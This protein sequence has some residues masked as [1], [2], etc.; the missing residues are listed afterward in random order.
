MTS[1]TGN[2]VRSLGAIPIISVL[3]NNPTLEQTTTNPAL[4]VPYI[5]YYTS[6]L[7]EYQAIR[8][9]TKKADGTYTTVTESRDILQ[10]QNSN[11]VYPKYLLYRPYRSMSAFPM[12]LAYKGSDVSAISARSRRTRSENRTPYQVLLHDIKESDIVLTYRQTKTALSSKSSSFDSFYN[13]TIGNV[14][15]ELIFNMCR[16]SV[17]G[18]TGDAVSQG[19]QYILATLMS[20]IYVPQLSGDPYKTLPLGNPPSGT[21]TTYRKVLDCLMFPD[22]NS[23]VN[24]KTGQY[25]YTLNAKKVPIPSKT[26]NDQG[27]S[28]ENDR[29]KIIPNTTVTVNAKDYTIKATQEIAFRTTA[30]GAAQIMGEYFYHLNYKSAAEMFIDMSARADHYFEYYDGGPNMNM[31]FLALQMQKFL[32]DSGKYRQMLGYYNSGSDGVKSLSLIT[33]EEIENGDQS[34][35]LNITTDLADSVLYQFAKKY[36]G[37]NVAKPT[38]YHS[39]YPVKLKN[40]LENLKEN[41]GKLKLEMAWGKYYLPCTYKV[42][43]NGKVTGDNSGTPTDVRVPDKEGKPGGP[44]NVFELSA[45]DWRAIPSDLKDGGLVGP[46]YLKCPKEFKDI[47]NMLMQM[48]TLAL[49]VKFLPEN[50]DNGRKTLYGKYGEYIEYIPWAIC[51]VESGMKNY[52][53]LKCPPITELLNTNTPMKDGDIRTTLT[54]GDKIKHLTTN[55]NLTKFNDKILETALTGIYPNDVTSDKL[56]EIEEDP[57]DDDKKTGLIGSRYIHILNTS[58]GIL[59]NIKSTVEHAT[60]TFVTTDARSRALLRLLDDTIK[61]LTDLVKPSKG[62]DI[63][64]PKIAKRYKMYLQVI[65]TVVSKV[66]SICIIPGIR[67]YSTGT[68]IMATMTFNANVTVILLTIVAE[69]FD[70]LSKPKPKSIPYLKDTLSF[71]KYLLY[72]TGIKKMLSGGEQISEALLAERYN[73]QVRSQYGT[74]IDRIY[75]MLKV[76]VDVVNTDDD[77]DRQYLTEVGAEILRAS[78]TNDAVWSIESERLHNSKATKGRSNGIYKD[79]VVPNVSDDI[80]V[81]DTLKN[82][83]LIDPDVP[84]VSESESEPPQDF[85]QAVN[86]FN[87]GLLS[88]YSLFNKTRTT[89]IM[90]YRNLVIKTEEDRANKTATT[91]TSY[92]VQFGSNN[93]PIY[94]DGHE[95][96]IVQ[97]FGGSKPSIV[98]SLVTNDVFML[99]DIMAACQELEITFRT[100]STLRNPNPLSPNFAVGGSDYQQNS[101]LYNVTRKNLTNRIKAIA[102]SDASSIIGE[103]GVDAPILITNNVANMCG[104]YACIFNTMRASTMEGFP[105]TWNIDL[106]FTGVDISQEYR[107]TPRKKKTELDP[108]IMITDLAR[109]NYLSNILQFYSGKNKSLET[110]AY[111]TNFQV[112]SNATIANFITFVA[113]TYLLKLGI[114]DTDLPKPLQQFT[115]KDPSM[116]DLSE[117]AIHAFLTYF[118]HPVMESLGGVLTHTGI[119]NITHQD[120]VNKINDR[121]KAIATDFRLCMHSNKYSY[122]PIIIQDP[123]KGK[124]TEIAQGMA[125]ISIVGVAAIAGGVLPIAVAYTASS[126]LQHRLR[127]MF[128]EAVKLAPMSLLQILSFTPEGYERN[129]KHRSDAIKKYAEDNKGDQEKTADVTETEAAKVVAIQWL[130]GPDDNAPI[131]SKNF[132]PIFQN[133]IKDRLVN[134]VVTTESRG[135]YGIINSKIFNPKINHKDL[136]KTEDDDYNLSVLDLSYHIIGEFSHLL[137]NYEGFDINEKGPD[138]KYRKKIRSWYNI[139]NAQNI[140]QSTDIALASIV[141]ALRE[142]RK[143]KLFDNVISTAMKAPKNSVEDLTE[144]IQKASTDSTDKDHA[145]ASSCKLLYPE[146]VSNGGQ[147]EIPQT[148]LTMSGK[149]THKLAE[150][151]RSLSGSYYMSKVF[152]DVI[153]LPIN[154]DTHRRTTLAGITSIKEILKRFKDYD[155]KCTPIKREEYYSDE[156]S[157]IAVVKS[158]VD[159]IEEGSPYI[160]ILPVTAGANS[161]ATKDN[162]LKTFLYFTPDAYALHRAKIIMYRLLDMFSK[163][164]VMPILDDV[165]ASFKDKALTNI[166]YEVSI[167]SQFTAILKDKS[168]TPDFNP[169]NMF[170]NIALKYMFLLMPKDSLRFFD[171]YN[172]YPDR[173]LPVL[174][175]ISDNDPNLQ[176]IAALQLFTTPDFFIMKDV[177]YL[178]NLM[179]NISSNIGQSRN[180]MQVEEA[181]LLSQADRDKDASASPQQAEYR[182]IIMNLSEKIPEALAVARAKYDDQK[183]QLM[184]RIGSIQSSKPVKPASPPKK[185]ATAIVEALQDSTA[186]KTE[187]MKIANALQELQSYT[188]NTNADISVPCQRFNDQLAIS[189]EL[190]SLSRIAAGLDQSDN[191]LGTMDMAMT[192]LRTNPAA[193]VSSRD[194]AMIKQLMAPGAGAYTMSSFNLMQSKLDMLYTKLRNTCLVSTMA[195]AFPTFKLYI[196]EEDA[197]EWLFF[198]DFYSYAAVKSIKIHKSRKSATETAYIEVSNIY[199]RLTNM[200]AGRRTSVENPFFIRS[201]DEEEVNTMMLKVG[202][203]LQIRLGYNANL[204]VDSIVFSG[205]IQEL[206]GT[207]QVIIVAQSHGVELTREI[208]QGS[209]TDFGGFFSRIS[210]IT[211]ATWQ[212]LGGKNGSLAARNTAT[213]LGLISAILSEAGTPL[214]GVGS[215]TPNFGIKRIREIDPSDNLG[216]GGLI[217]QWLA[218]KITNNFLNLDVDLIDTRLTN[219]NVDDVISN[220][221]VDTLIGHSRWLIYNETIWDA[222]QDYVL[223][224]GNKMCIVRSYDEDNTLVIDSDDGIYQ[225]SDENTIETGRLLPIITSLKK[226]EKSA[227]DAIGIIGQLL[228]SETN[229][230]TPTSRTPIRDVVSLMLRRTIITTMLS[231]TNPDLK[232]QEVIENIDKIVDNAITSMIETDPKAEKIAK[233]LDNASASAIDDMRETPLV[234]K[235]K[236]GQALLKMLNTIEDNAMQEMYKY[237]AIAFSVQHIAKMLKVHVAARNRAFRMV[238]ELHIKTADKDIIKNNIKTVQGFN[239]VA[240]SYVEPNALGTIAQMLPGADA[241]SN[242]TGF[243]TSISLD[244]ANKPSARTK[245]TVAASPKLKKDRIQT[246][247]TF[248]KNAAIRGSTF[249]DNPQIVANSI[250]ANLIRDYYDG[251]LIIIMDPTIEVGDTIFMQDHVNDM[252]GMIQVKEV[253]HSFDPATGAVTIIKP[254]VY[255]RNNID[256]TRITDKFDGWMRLAMSAIEV[257]AFAAFAWFGGAMLSKATSGLLTAFSKVRQFVF[258]QAAKSALTRLGASKGATVATDIV[259]SLVP[260]VKAEVMANII[261]NGMERGVSGKK[262]SA[263]ASGADPKDLIKAATEEYFDEFTVILQRARRA[264]GPKAQAANAIL[265]ILDGMTKKSNPNSD[266]TALMNNAKFKTLLNREDTKKAVID[267]LEENISKNASFMTTSVLTDYR[268][269]NKI[270][271][272]FI[273]GP[274]TAAKAILRADITKLP[275][276]LFHSMSFKI[277]KFAPDAI[278]SFNS[279]VGEYAHQKPIIISGLIHKGEPMM[280]NLDGMTKSEFNNLADFIKY[281]VGETLDPYYTAIG[282]IESLSY[283]LTTGHLKNLQI[284]H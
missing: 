222:L 168:L 51:L 187:L 82:A 129:L 57:L 128:T 54:E 138:E 225:R 23:K 151:L 243:G 114:E 49:N 31:K 140:L 156:I 55:A 239:R 131:S 259:D 177:Q 2:V 245:L 24:D 61:E 205:R 141:V 120:I 179:K 75:N 204:G 118:A 40:I 117:F 262:I 58:V 112:A 214:R 171:M 53:E 216:V 3:E 280:E 83:I 115:K 194:I 271:N 10:K 109:H 244:T 195:M 104:I 220:N 175:N 283:D 41:G 99:D 166:S 80:L 30:I 5:K 33:H 76:L 263:L 261:R 4:S 232:S 38:D 14:V 270:V 44:V 84:V 281:K 226:A 252:W 170:S 106:T 200:M 276:I 1:D 125:K 34:R 253:T 69:T 264:T 237:Y 110:A 228:S 210:G 174:L 147:T 56:P 235:H 50:S 52:V 198:N 202:A 223:Q 163:Y 256:A 224:L 167:K 7:E 169:V 161:V 275:S 122:I 12:M 28:I 90:E 250:L 123:E 102:S 27:R 63:D 165:Y 136:I 251:E 246:Y 215:T 18:A 267:I 196:I 95:T 241:I 45:S 284:F 139:D 9:R 213:S 16:S 238:S 65:A 39:P 233:I 185:M 258:K 269:M 209:G 242:A 219:V 35:F 132:A 71:S 127:E 282:D 257:I 107:E 277:G 203:R 15:K 42:D 173:P 113:I 236:S 186:G 137:G 152:C 37:P 20:P 6:Q 130:K 172:A 94:M 153:A 29:Y 159:P 72:Q 26:E 19:K 66:L 212:T 211:N 96:P 8:S 266:M 62:L 126:D 184:D 67:A 227:V 11:Y 135:R 77:I 217:S 176:K 268:V 188:N 247:G 133:V 155:S 154:N 121:I 254:D 73:S 207:D 150:L 43:K 46:Y 192:R 255:V 143:Y 234:D 178:D 68:D 86:T 25:W 197:K 98:L 265:K 189:S 272:N 101:I 191:V 81:N 88:L 116:M 193:K 59:K 47:G 162:R 218:Q 206:Q 22:K 249:M 180:A 190:T 79:I 91:I 124:V 17:I 229:R 279:L 64:V 60:T 146:I 13:L 230:M 111:V 157:E 93:I 89:D 248:Q 142:S 100:R 158:N 32:Q 164:I 201:S 231:Q 103:G 208:G 199:G 70:K 85:S 97:N 145:L 74:N 221:A 240:M 48:L 105:G 78:Q 160:Q 260:K 87:L 144:H 134:S 21:R 278:N 183:S 181:A 274:G 36:A 273:G 182:R 149:V 119:S 148:G 92:Q 108:M